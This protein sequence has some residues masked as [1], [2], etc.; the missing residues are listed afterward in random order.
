MVQAYLGYAHALAGRDDQAMQLLA[1]S[2]AADW[3]FH[4]A[5]RVTMQGEAH[6]LAGRWDLAQ[7]C[8]DRALALADLG[9][10]HGG[11]A[12]TLRF[13]AEVVLATEGLKSADRAAAQYGAALALA[14]DLGMR[15]LQAHCHLGL[16][17]LYRRTDRVADA[18]VELTTAMTMLHEMGM[19]L[20][21]REAEAELAETS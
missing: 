8:V 14:T 7:Q 4:P 17:K 20:W 11:R 6:L 12:W 18:R 5:L 15:P 2:A 19:A 16:G 1:E 3:G 9:E 13:A 10:E 21:L